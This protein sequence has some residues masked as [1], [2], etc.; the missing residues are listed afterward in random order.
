MQDVLMDLGL[1]SILLVVAFYAR[2][3]IKI[4]Q[5][6]YIP[7]TVIAGA[8]GLLLGPNVLGKVS[9]VYLPFS[10]GS[11]WYAGILLV[12]VFTTLCVGAEFGFSLGYIAKFSF[13]C[14]CLGSTL[15]IGQ[16]VLGYG[17]VK[18]LQMTG[19]NIL[20]GFALL[21]STGFYG[22][23]GLGATVAAAWESIDY[24]NPE[25]VNSI[26]TTFATIGLLH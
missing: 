11:A 12:V 1:I 23:H 19:S 8:I 18:V 6:L 2:A 9:P 26:A 7:V 13:Q 25:E 24:W 20:D 10:A 14:L 15:L 3:K 17:I 5:R 21:P 4:L 16:A 22:G